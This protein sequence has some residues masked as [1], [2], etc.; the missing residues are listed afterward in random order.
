MKSVFSKCFET[1]P[2][3]VTGTFNCLGEHGLRVEVG[4]VDEDVV[5]VFLGRKDCASPIYIH[6]DTAR[7][8]ADFFTTLTDALEKD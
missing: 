1:R 3:V 6:L 2:R 4:E 8:L 5:E 7:V